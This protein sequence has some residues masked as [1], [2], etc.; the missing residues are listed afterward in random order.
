MSRT[1]VIVNVV[2]LKMQKKD[3]M[4]ANYLDMSLKGPSKIMNLNLWPVI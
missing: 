1:G 3:F 4:P 2:M